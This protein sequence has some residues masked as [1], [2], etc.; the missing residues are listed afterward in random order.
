MAC[1]GRTRRPP[2]GFFS[3]ERVSEEDILG[4]HFRASDRFAMRDGCV[5]VLHDTAEFSFQRE[6]SE[7][8]GV[9]Y[10]V[11]SGRDKAGRLRS[12]TGRVILMHTS[13]DGRRAS[14][15]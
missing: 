6:S 13:A 15:S 3:N 5:L 8:I 12:H 9:T 1:Q 4:G 10:N 2:N 11:N 7:A 14:P